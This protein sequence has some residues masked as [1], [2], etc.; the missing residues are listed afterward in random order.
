MGR[1]KAA[2]PLVKRKIVIRKSTSDAVDAFIIDPVTGKAKHGEWSKL[3]ESLLRQHLKEVANVTF[4]DLL[5]DSH[6]EDNAGIDPCR[7]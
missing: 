3:V 6:P 2:E 1:R 4:D 5:I 7:K